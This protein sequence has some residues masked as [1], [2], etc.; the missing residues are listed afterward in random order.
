MGTESRGAARMEGDRMEQAARDLP[1]EAT[2]EVDVTHDTI[3][4]T[5]AAVTGTF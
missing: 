1:G 5:A 3:C 4:R 2:D